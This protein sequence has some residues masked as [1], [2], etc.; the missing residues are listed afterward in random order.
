M[1]PPL[2]RRSFGSVP[3]HQVNRS[4]EFS[5]LKNSAECDCP[6][7]CRQL[8]SELHAGFIERA[9]GIVERT[10]DSYLCEVSPLVSYAGEGLEHLKGQTFQCPVHIQ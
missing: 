1:P 7:T 2:H 3:A 10:S 5:P 9:G 6:E 4:Q 8:I